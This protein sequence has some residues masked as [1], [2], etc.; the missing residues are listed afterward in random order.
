[1]KPTPQQKEDA[2]PSLDDKDAEK[3]K[4]EKRKADL[5]ASKPLTPAQSSQLLSPIV[6]DV[7]S[8][9]PEWKIFTTERPIPGG[10]SMAIIPYAGGQG[11]ILPWKKS[12]KELQNDYKDFQKAVGDEMIRQ[13]QGHRIKEVL[14]GYFGDSANPQSEYAPQPMEAP[15]AS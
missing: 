13:G 10:A 1:M 12:E 4:D 3:A 2:K 7:V 8:E 6:A 11:S 9:H 14:P 15:P 5:A